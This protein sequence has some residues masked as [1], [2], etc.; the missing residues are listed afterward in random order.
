MANLNSLV[1]TSSDY[2]MSLTIKGDSNTTVTGV[3][4]LEEVK[5]NAKTE[6]EFL[7]V[8]GT[9]QPVALKTEGYTYEGNFSLQ[10]GE[11][12]QALKDAGNLFLTETIDGVI[13]ITALNGSF[14]R[15]FNSV[16]FDDHAGGTKAKDK[17]SKV[18][19]NW[20][21]LSVK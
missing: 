15:T 20:K 14:S 6:S 1:F 17:D 19:I 18:T 13:A 8:V 9:K 16:I 11:L 12:E 7:H 10:A 4:T 21:A 2:N 3:A 5:Y